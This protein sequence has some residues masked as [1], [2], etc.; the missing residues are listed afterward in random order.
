MSA[1]SENTP[2]LAQ[3]DDVGAKLSS[4]VARLHPQQGRLE[5]ARFKSPVTKITTVDSPIRP[6]RKA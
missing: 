4:P 6:L 3:S 1:N 2:Q 5:G